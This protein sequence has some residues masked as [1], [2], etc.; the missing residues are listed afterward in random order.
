M[1]TIRSFVSHRSRIKGDKMENYTKMLAKWSVKNADDIQKLMQNFD[2][3]EVEI[4]SGYGDTIIH[5]AKNNP[6]ML[7][8]ACEVYRDAIYSICKKIEEGNIQ[9][10]RIF[11]QD[12]RELLHTFSDGFVDGIY[13]LFPDPWPKARHHKR[14]IVT[15]DFFKNQSRILKKNGVLFIATDSDSYKQHIAVEIL[16]QKFFKWNAKTH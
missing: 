13:L 8:L 14:R 1:H 12:A 15:Q 11:T 6:K 9:N 4:G 2:G 7:F 3:F 10:I 5:L 16:H